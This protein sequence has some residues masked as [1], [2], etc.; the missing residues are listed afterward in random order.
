GPHPEEALELAAVFQNSDLGRRA[1]VSL[2][3]ER[4]W[5]FIADLDGTLIRGSI[6]L[7]FEE[8]GGI[9]I[10]DYKTDSTIR[11]SEYAPQVALYAAALERAFGKRPARASLYYL[12]ANIVEEVPLDDAAMER[13]REL[14]ASIREAQEDLAFG[15]NE[16]PHCRVCPYFRSLCPAAG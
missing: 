4:E 13:A 6:D 8:P 12:R 14:I 11:T 7:W 3:S 16:G 5:E 2:R 1:A 10:V 15:L 9:H